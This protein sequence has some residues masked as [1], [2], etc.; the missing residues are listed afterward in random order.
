LHDY[1]SG[2]V[3]RKLNVFSTNDIRCSTKNIS[4]IAQ[5]DCRAD[6][7]DPIC[8]YNRTWNRRFRPA[9]GTT[10]YPLMEVHQSSWTFRRLKT[11][12]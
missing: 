1:N 12:W 4:L 11:L 8:Q 3:Y 10:V 7:P 6:N 2:L 9:S 5:W